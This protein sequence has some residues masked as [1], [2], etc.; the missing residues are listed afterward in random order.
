MALQNQNGNE[1]D[2]MK[3][4]T[5]LMLWST[6]MKNYSYKREKSKYRP[7]VC[8]YARTNANA[9][10]R[11]MKYIMMTTT[12]TTAAT[13]AA[14]ATTTA[15]KEK[16]IFNVARND[17]VH[18][19]HF[20]PSYFNG[21]HVFLAPFSPSYYS[22]AARTRKRTKTR[23]RE[24]HTHRE[25]ENV[26]RAKEI[27]NELLRLIDAIIAWETSI[28]CC[29]MRYMHIKR[30]KH[31]TN[32]MLSDHI[33]LYIDSLN[34]VFKRLS[35]RYDQIINFE[36]SLFFSRSPSLSRSDWSRF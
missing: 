2:W 24:I 28:T 15:K 31:N 30:H 20:F 35:S 36:Y 23:A 25:R 27:Q 11:E 29:R 1:I 13:T 8:D 5:F 21:L 7:T 3:T 6:I 34:C 16:Q 4:T 19:A 32:Q 26:D 17:M 10:P 12:M 33:I 14:T 9:K 22:S 18:A